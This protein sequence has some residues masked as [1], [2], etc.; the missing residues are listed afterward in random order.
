[1]PQVPLSGT[2]LPPRNNPY[3]ANHLH[4][5]PSPLIAPSLCRSTESKPN[6]QILNSTKVSSRVNFNSANAQNLGK[7]P[8]KR[9]DDQNLKGRK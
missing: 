9:F 8:R 3:A 4:D 6:R 7:I 5:N 2:A 1:V